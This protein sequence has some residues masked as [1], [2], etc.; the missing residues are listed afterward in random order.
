MHGAQSPANG[1]IAVYLSFSHFVTLR[2][3]LR[4]LEAGKNLLIDL[5][6]GASVFFVDDSAASV[7][8]LSSGVVERGT[9]SK[10]LLITLDRACHN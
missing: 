5:L 9:I 10:L 7:T 6:P 4:S 3:F 2:S 8:R 1:D